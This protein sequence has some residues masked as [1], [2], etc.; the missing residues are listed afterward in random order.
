MMRLDWNNAIAGRPGA[1][2][3]G[4]LSP[5]GAPERCHSDRT[6]IA[7]A[8]ALARRGIPFRGDLTQAF[9]A[10]HRRA[11]DIHLGESA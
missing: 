10:L 11:V 1:D 3:W 7:T 6:G 8:N 5:A 9:V 4:C 2:D